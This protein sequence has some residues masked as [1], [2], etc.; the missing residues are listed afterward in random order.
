MPAHRRRAAEC[1]WLSVQKDGGNSLAR[2][3][4]LYMR[5]LAVRD[6]EVARAFA[7]PLVAG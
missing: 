4:S 7:V 1:F 5:Q 2:Q 3:L 6:L